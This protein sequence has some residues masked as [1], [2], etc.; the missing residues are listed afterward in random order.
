MS[1]SRKKSRIQ[2]YPDPD[3]GTGY[4]TKF[5]NMSGRVFWGHL[6]DVFGYKMCMMLVTVLISLLYATLYFA[7]FGGKV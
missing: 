2:P 1:G 3:I 7:E 4:N 5:Y 6:C